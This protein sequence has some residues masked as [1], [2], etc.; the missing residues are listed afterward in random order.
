MVITRL[1][2]QF[3]SENQ[4]QV[5]QKKLNSFRYQRLCNI[6]ACFDKL[7]FKVPNLIAELNLDEIKNGLNIGSI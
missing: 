1:Y 7:Y 3:L 6:R 2:I 4:N 5:L